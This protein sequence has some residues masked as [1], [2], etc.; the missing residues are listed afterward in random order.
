MFG[1][2]VC[3]LAVLQLGSFKKLLQGHAVDS[4][5]VINDNVSPIPSVLIWTLEKIS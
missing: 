4:K 1:G 5:A 3:C 2:K